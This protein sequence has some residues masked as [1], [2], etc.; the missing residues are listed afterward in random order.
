MRV[1]REGH[2]G[3]LVGLEGVVGYR[4]VWFAG[5]GDMAGRVGSYS[6]HCVGYGLALKQPPAWRH[7][8]LDAVHRGGVLRSANQA[9]A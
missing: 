3:G 9:T 1:N 5:N 2:T 7:L 6:G 4:E 8:A